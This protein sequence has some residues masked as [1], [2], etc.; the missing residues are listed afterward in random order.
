MSLSTS[1]RSTASTLGSDSW[2]PRCPKNNILDSVCVSGQPARSVRIGLLAANQHP[3]HDTIVT[4]R[5]RFLIQIETL[6]VQVLLMAR[7]M[8]VLKLGTEALD[9]TKIHADASRH[10]ALSYERAGQIEMQLREEVAKALCPRAGR[11]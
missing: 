6:F 1:I 4:F 2:E 7:E 10:S 11:V 5:P 8:G 9:G 3:D